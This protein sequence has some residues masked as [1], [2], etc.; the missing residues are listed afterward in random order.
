M[1]N[2]EGSHPDPR[3]FLRLVLKA[4]WMDNTPDEVIALWKARIEAGGQFPRQALECLEGVIVHPPADLVKLLQE[5]GWIF[6]THEEGSKEWPFSFD[7]HVEWLR[8][9]VGALRRIFQEKT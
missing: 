3:S 4:I 6:L 5:N 2:E 8:H 7:E 9:Q 1:M